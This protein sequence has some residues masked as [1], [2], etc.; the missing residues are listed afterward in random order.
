M[1][2]GVLCVCVWSYILSKAKN[3]LLMNQSIRTFSRLEIRGKERA[4]KSTRKGAK[5]VDGGKKIYELG[6]IAT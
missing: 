2:G 5:R 3:R 1:T 6:I 4:N